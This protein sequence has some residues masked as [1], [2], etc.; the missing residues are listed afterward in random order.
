M[1]ICCK[2]NSREEELNNCCC[3]MCR[4]PITTLEGNVSHMKLTLQAAASQ[5]KVSSNISKLVGGI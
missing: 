1:T 3:P 4:Q 5:M 2:Y